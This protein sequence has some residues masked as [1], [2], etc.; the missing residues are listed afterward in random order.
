MHCWYANIY[1]AVHI[2]K[3]ID[4][5]TVNKIVLAIQPMNLGKVIFFAYSDS[6]V[7]YRDRVTMAETLNDGDLNR[8]WHLSQVGFTY[9]EDDPC[10]CHVLLTL[11]ASDFSKGLQ[12]ALSPSYSSVVQIRNDGKVKW[13]HLE[14]H[15][16]DI[17]SSMEDGKFCSPSTHI[18]LN[19]IAQYSAVVAALALSCST[20]V[21]RNVNYDD[22]IA[23]AH[24][25]AKGGMHR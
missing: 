18:L 19:C 14:Y 25:H 23:T 3:K 20:A 6:S 22:L 16:G 15:L 13:K 12:V 21:M 9:A 1:Q 17:G 10:E 5:F 7:E 2:L 24:K 8:V 11:M 4:S